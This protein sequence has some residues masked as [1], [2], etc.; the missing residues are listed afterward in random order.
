MIDG[1]VTAYKRGIFKAGNIDLASR[2][3]TNYNA[4]SKMDMEP[5][6]N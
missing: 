1:H 2:T 4:Y 6:N 5:F 3:V